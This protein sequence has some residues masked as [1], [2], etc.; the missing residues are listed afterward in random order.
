MNTRA[1]L[2]PAGRAATILW[3]SAVSIIVATGATTSVGAGE[4][5][6]NPFGAKPAASASAAGSN[7]DGTP[8]NPFGPKPDPN[9]V[10]SAGTTLGQTGVRAGDEGIAKLRAM[11]LQRFDKNGAGTL[12]A[13]ELTEA[14]KVLSGR[15]NVRPVTPAQAARAANGP[16]FGLRPLLNRFDPN[17]DGVFDDAALAEIHQFLFPN[18]IATPA[19]ASDLDTLRQAIV[20]RFDQK[21][22]GKLDD[23][24]RA[25]ATAFLQQMI[26]DLDQTGRTGGGKN[27]APPP[28]PSL[29]PPK[30]AAGASGPGR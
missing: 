28:S 15:T 26:A 8:A 11:L 9:A 12:D 6:G 27:S 17:D 24:E 4:V 13:A 14:R 1:F 29:P 5:P 7:A 20:T 3:A 2:I 10:G 22:D 23:A 30:A 21:G 19:A 18:A 16:L 25:A